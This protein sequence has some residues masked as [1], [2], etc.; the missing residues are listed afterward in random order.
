[1]NSQRLTRR[2]VGRSLGPLGFPVRHARRCKRASETA[3]CS[4]PIGV[5]Q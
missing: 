1:M 3:A 2:S 4:N 5:R